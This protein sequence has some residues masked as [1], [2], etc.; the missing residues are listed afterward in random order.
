MKKIFTKLMLV[1]M[2]LLPMTTFSQKSYSK[3]L[4]ATFSGGN[5]GGLSGNL[6]TDV[7]PTINA[8][9]GILDVAVNKVGGNW[10][11]LWWY[12]ANCWTKNIV[13]DQTNRY[14][15]FR[16]KC[17]TPQTTPM[18]LYPSWGGC[19]GCCA[20]T[21]TWVNPTFII[22]NADEW[23]I[24]FFRI[25]STI[26]GTQNVIDTVQ[27]SVAW[28]FANGNYSIDYIY[29]GTC[30]A[31]PTP[32]I[33][34]V[35]TKTV[36]ACAGV[37]N[38]TLSNISIPGRLID[39]LTIK[40]EALGDGILTDVNIL[41]L[42]DGPLAVDEGTNIATAALQYTPVEGMGGMGDSIVITLKDTIRNTTV[43][44]S[45]Y[46]NLLV[47]G[48]IG[49]SDIKNNVSIYP[50]TVDNVVNIDLSAAVTGDIIVLDMVGNVISSQKLAETTNTK[51]DLSK[52]SSGMYIIKISDGKDVITQK[53]V[54]K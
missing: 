17:A 40:A 44:S 48:C 25:A 37:Q 53:I 45:F 8:V 29:M 10:S 1:L 34:I 16:V 3:C 11:V 43:K 33:D 24:K 27:N 54:K 5:N 49:L 46:V 32:T 7:I 23:E 4:S 31:P 52:A 12:M 42:G 6:A 21:K 22:P 50:T 35:K 38:V 30:A 13:F 2:L 51:V 41:D 14:I 18:T 36:K 28:G 15:E 20:Q 26:G 39:G 9:D 47:G 19:D